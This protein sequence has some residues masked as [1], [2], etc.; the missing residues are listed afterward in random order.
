MDFSRIMGLDLGD[1]RI[2]IAISD[3]LKITAQGIE[4]Y[5]RKSLPEDLAYIKKLC[6][7]NNVEKIVCGFPKNMN[8]TVGPSAQKA[9][10]FADQLKEKTGLDVVMEDERLTTMLA[11]RVLIE[12]D[13]SR[14]KRRKVVDKLA[15]VTILQGYLDRMSN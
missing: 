2:G 14:A 5:T 9:L 1:V 6:K 10:D 15:A 11:E 12:A 13:V 7:A 4:S 8:N 3:P